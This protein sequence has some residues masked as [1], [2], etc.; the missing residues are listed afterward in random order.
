[1]DH[2][3]K[4]TESCEKKRDT[5]RVCNSCCI[6]KTAQ[7]PLTTTDESWTQEEIYPGVILIPE[8]DAKYIKKENG[9]DQIVASYNETSTRPGSYDVKYECPPQSSTLRCRLQLTRQLKKN[10]EESN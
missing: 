4:A 2:K 7:I 5:I 8:M 6:A 1:M 9:Q 3:Y 10:K